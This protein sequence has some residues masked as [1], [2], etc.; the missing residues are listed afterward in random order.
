MSIEER[1]LEIIKRLFSVEREAVLDQIES[2]ISSD[3][4]NPSD[5]LFSA[6]SEAK[7][8]YLKGEGKSH[9]SV[10]STMQL[11]YPNLF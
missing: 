6:L 3:Y 8:S 11:K 9:D 2:L 10:M 4:P 7:S 1:K 5:E